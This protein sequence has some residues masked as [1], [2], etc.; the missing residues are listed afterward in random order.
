MKWTFVRLNFH[1]LDDKKFS[2]PKFNCYLW[3][4]IKYAIDAIEAIDAIDAIIK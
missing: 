4:V 1:T 3:E 2:F